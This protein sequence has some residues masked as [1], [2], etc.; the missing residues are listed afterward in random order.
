MPCGTAEARLLRSVVIFLAGGLIGTLVGIAGGI[1]VYPYVFLAD[2]VAAKQVA[3]GD[4]RA[5]LATGS[6]VARS[7]TAAVGSRSITTSCIWRMTSR[8]ARGRSSTS[9]WSGARR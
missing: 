8:S 2:V 1:F 9:I 5:I 3:D 6:F 7:T 4:R